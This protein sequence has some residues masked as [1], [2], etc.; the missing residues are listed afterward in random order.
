MRGCTVCIHEPLHDEAVQLRT[1]YPALAFV[2][3]GHGLCR[4]R[5]RRGRLQDGLLLGSR[6]GTEP[7]EEEL[8]LQLLLLVLRVKRGH[9]STV[10]HAALEELV[11]LLR[12]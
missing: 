1:N 8:R 12:V 4:C 5:C 3:L 7:L 2:R 9:N 11:P 10:G 6:H